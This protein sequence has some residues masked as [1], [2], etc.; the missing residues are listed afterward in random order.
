M[1]WPSVPLGQIAELIGGSTPSRDR[2]EFWGGSIPWITPTDLP[3]PGKGIAIVADSSEKITEEGLAS[4]SANLLPVGTVL[5]SSRATIGKLA[6]TKVPVAT[7]QGFANFVAGPAVDNRY[8][9]WVLQHQTPSILRLAGSTTFKEVTKTSLKTFPIPLPP[10]SEQRRIAEILD[11]VARLRALR[12]AADAKSAGIL[13][14]GF[15]HYFGRSE[16]W[17]P[18]SCE[19]TEA[20]GNL[21]SI[22]SGGTP[23]KAVAEYWDGDIP[24]VS[25]KD[26]KRAFL[27]D[28]E[29]HISR[30][31]LEDG[32]AS[33]VPVNSL[34]IVV[35]G[36]IL[37]RRVPIGM[38][39]KPVAINQDIKA[40]TISDE[41]VSSLFLL[42]A[43]QALD[44]TLFE[45]VSTAAH[46]TRKLDTERLLSLRIPVPR[47]A[48]HEAYCDWFQELR[49]VQDTQEQARDDL[50][51]IFTVVLD[52]AF[53]GRLT[54]KWRAA[55]M[56]KLAGEINEQA[57]LLERAR[58]IT[59]EVLK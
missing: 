53:S 8:L 50:E 41:R 9:A 25:P 29:D 12:L 16:A 18:R 54:E 48:E 4:S 40:L 30:K 45:R 56:L 19:T 1:R 55:H 23:S 57:R 22:S 15:E 36:M 42:A 59:T 21:V 20:L 2:P 14:A 49:K 52:R 51:R 26:M 47:R 6:I 37:A 27:E 31:A 43:L 5:F 35:R 24:W 10:L 44:Q 39:L 3:M 33:T 11:E 7:N 34:L 58:Q 28:S 17:H 46:G 32:A 38:N 13:R